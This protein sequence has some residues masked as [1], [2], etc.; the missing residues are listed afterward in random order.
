MGMR[1]QRL[2]ELGGRCRL[3]PSKLCNSTCFWLEVPIC[4]LS[5]SWWVGRIQAWVLRKLKEGKVENISYYLSIS[6][7]LFFASGLFYCWVSLCYFL[8]GSNGV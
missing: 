1:F 2:G 5:F 7:C 3:F 8:H 6:C 4:R